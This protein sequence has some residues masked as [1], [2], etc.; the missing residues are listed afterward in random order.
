M[1]PLS[2]YHLPLLVTPSLWPL[3]PII[4][5]LPTTPESSI[6]REDS[7]IGYKLSAKGLS[8]ETVC[9]NSQVTSKVRSSGLA[10]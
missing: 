8:R 3:V 2:L 5:T 6:L 9:L 7:C 10:I 1:Q 4:L